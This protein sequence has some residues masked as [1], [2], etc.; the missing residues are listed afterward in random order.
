MIRVL[1][2][3]L[4][5][6]LA[7]FPVAAQEWERNQLNI[8]DGFL[9]LY[10]PHVIWEPDEEYPFKMWF[11]G[12]SVAI[13]NPGYSGCDAIWHARSKDLEH[14]E[15]YK[16][17]GQW[18]SSGNSNLW[19]PVIMPGNI[20]YD[21]VHN[22]DP[23]VV[24]HNGYYYMAFSSTGNDLDGKPDGT[25]GDTDDDLYCIQMARS[26]D[27]IVWEKAPEPVLIHQAIIGKPDYFLPG[28]QSYDVNYTGDFA[29]PSLMWDGDHWRMWFDYWT[30]R[31]GGVCTG[32]AEN[33]GDPM[34]SDDWVITHDLLN[35]PVISVWTNPDV[36]KVDG[37]Y[38]SFAD[39]PGY[40]SP[41]GP[42][43]W[44]SRQIAEAESEDGLH[45]TK[46]DP[47]HIPPDTD[48]PTNQVPEAVEIEMDG[49]RWLY[50]FYANQRGGGDG[51]LGS[52]DYMYKDLRFMRRLIGPAYIPTPT[53]LPA[54]VISWQFY[55]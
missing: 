8:L 50:L 4:I 33:Y 53:P 2:I 14:W 25:P 52:Y 42:L 46:K 15:V 3:F 32:H 21:Q 31:Y 49:S 20:Y 55:R 45:W 51:S 22:G 27:G 48:S 39:P 40:A 37:I 38:Y 6:V 1:H 13:C 54:G 17:N 29:R 16:G 23:S 41:V 19:V 5:F 18:D 30:V 7:V 28:T 47:L 10:Q 43:I 11:M 36:V 35:A 44:T 24:K 34:N 26:E 12:W 9:N